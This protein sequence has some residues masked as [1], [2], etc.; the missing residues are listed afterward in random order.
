MKKQF[1]SINKIEKLKTHRF[2][3]KKMMLK[4]VNMH[5]LNWCNGGVVNKFIKYNQNKNLERL[6]E[7]VKKNLNKR[8]T[9]FYAIFF[10]DKHIGNIKC[11]RINFK[12]SFAHL[13]ILIGDKKFKKKGAEFEI[14]DKVCDELFYSYNISKVFS[15]VVKKNIEVLN[16]Y[17]KAGFVIIKS[18]NSKTHL[19]CRNFFINKIVLGTAQLGSNYGIA[20]KTGKILIKD[21]K[22]IKQLALKEGMITVET[23]Q[24]Y[25]NSEKI[26]GNVNFNKFNLISKIKKI[27][28]NNIKNLKNLI[29]NSVKKSL[30]KMKIK[31]IYAFLF[32]N[33]ENLLS[34]NGKEIFNALNMLKKNGTIENIGVAVYNVS[35]LET[36]SK[37]YK[38]DIISIPFNLLDRRFEKSK[39]V[40]KLK[41]QN[42]KFYARSVFLQGL[43]L[44]KSDKMSKY[45]KKWKKTFNS[46][47]NYSKK[48]HISKFHM[49]LNFALSSKLIDKVVVGVN[50]FNQFRQII[51]Y[52]LNHKKIYLPR[53]KNVNYKIINPNLWKI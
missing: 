39:V 51:N 29:K 26:L 28:K 43:L 22:K 8:D 41:K 40:R 37:K 3:L 18:N 24:A 45:F 44:M 36:L 30:K 6:R 21:I 4:Y 47:E 14:I 25:K 27:D 35:E 11:E 31:K 34:K 9:L 46:L 5:Y 1:K 2:L 42:V 19:M 53:F 48:N 13:D 32:H 15:D 16:L 20:N 50:N 10:K 33:S 38:F 7:N 23:A 12:K 52:R 49:C 17:L